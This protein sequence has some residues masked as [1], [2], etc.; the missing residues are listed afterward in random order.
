MHKILIRTYVAACLIL[1][2]IL[3]FDRA[4]AAPD[5]RP[6]TQVSLLAD[7]TR[8]ASDGTVALAL[9]MVPRKGWHLYWKNYGDTGAET[10]IDFSGWPTKTIISPWQYPTPARLP[11]GE[12]MNFGYK[13]PI[14]LLTTAT[15][16]KKTGTAQLSITAKI[17]WLACTEEVCVPED[18]TVVLAVPLAPGSVSSTTPGAALSNVKAIFAEGAKEV[19]RTPAW[20]AQFHVAAGQFQITIP[21]DIDLAATSAVEFFPNTA[22]LVLHVAPQLV[23]KKDRQIWLETTVDP[24]AVLG[25]VS[26]VVVLV[27]KD[28]SRRGYD[29]AFAKSD[30]ALA[31]PSDADVVGDMPVIIP[32][33]PAKPSLPFGLAFVFAVLGGLLLNLMPCVFPI[34]ALK[35]FSL[36]RAGESDRQ[37]RRDG[38]GYTAGVL[39][40]FALI[41]GALLALRSGGAAIGWGFQLQDPRI[42]AALGLLMVLIALNLAGLLDVGTR[43]GTVGTDLARQSGAAG[44]FWTGALAVVVATPCTAPF[45]A[46][47]LGAALALPPLA[48]V[49]IFLGLGL[50]M[51]LPFLALGF[52]PSVRRLLPRPGAWMESFKHFLAF[53][54]LATALWLFWVVGQLTDSTTMA[55]VIGAGLLLALAA[56]LWARPSKLARSAGVVMALCG[57]AVPVLALRLPPASA[58][59]SASAATTSPSARAATNAPYSDARLADLVKAGTP[60]FAYFTADWCISCKV[61]ER[62]ALNREEVAAAFKAQGVAILVGDWTKRDAALGK[63]LERYGRAGVPLYLYF[64]KGAALDKPLVLPQVLTP[65]LLIDTVT[66]PG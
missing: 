42:V 60:V 38:L 66:V 12:L 21:T 9:R 34:L 7:A 61:N 39:A 19:P 47:A 41:G 50:G 58:S 18:K 55:L 14:T 20:P 43:L 46:G 13:K 45:M 36:A 54:M 4:H 8:V 51:A 16:P 48:G 3:Q 64:P 10:K 63:V 49:G 27:T 44:A 59:A 5:T 32:G 40:T 31:P 37:A 25:D 65:G 26:G 35:A 17:S 57:L 23:L 53:P 30:V 15:L 62:V 2:G 52:L 24:A 22:P 33:R 11:F 1:A 28:G 56:W 29:L 6:D